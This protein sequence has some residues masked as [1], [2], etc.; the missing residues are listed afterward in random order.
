MD[1]TEE[2]V[3]GADRWE[4]YERISNYVVL[5]KGRQ[6]SINRVTKGRSEGKTNVNGPLTWCFIGTHVTTSG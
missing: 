3:A 4:E 1:R 5:G 2:I 6:W